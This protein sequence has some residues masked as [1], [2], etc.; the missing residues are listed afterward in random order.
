MAGDFRGGAVRL[1][2]LAG[3]LPEACAMAPGMGT[4]AYVLLM[5]LGNGLRFARSGRGE[6]VL[7][8]WLVYAGS[9]RGPGGIAAR[10]G[11][12]LRK[13]KPVR[14]HVDEL[15][16]AAHSVAALAVPGGTECGIVARLVESGRYQVAM[17]GFGS[18]DCRVCE[19]HLLRVGTG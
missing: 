10:V 8:G 6:A 1:S 13:V 9:A 16:N 3:L 17:K 7:G 12:H 4:G 2:E 11:R 19:G 15:T 18:S 14:W 5:D